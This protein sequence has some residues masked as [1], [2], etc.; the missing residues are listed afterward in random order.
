MSVPTL[1]TSYS[2]FQDADKKVV[3]MNIKELGESHAAFYQERCW[4]NSNFFRH[5]HEVSESIPSEELQFTTPEFD[6][7]TQH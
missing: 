5:F 4:I 6:E 1:R 2:Y 7:L 3:F